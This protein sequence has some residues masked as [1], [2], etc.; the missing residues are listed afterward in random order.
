MSSP[1]PQLPAPSPAAD[2]HGTYL[3]NAGLVLVWPFLTALFERLGY[4]A[5][6]QFLGIGQATRAAYLLQFLATGEDQPPEHLLALNKVLCGV[7]RTLPL[8][9]ELPLTPDEKATGESLLQAVIAR[10][11]TVLKN[12]S[13]AGLRETFLQRPGKLVWADDRITLTVETKTLDI[14]LDRR[15]WPIALIK[16]PWMPLPLYVTWR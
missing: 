4:V 10:W 16:L 5:E 7:G 3:V 15:P 6:R 14:L 8:R 9:R 11:G 13:L 2:P 1:R 12:T